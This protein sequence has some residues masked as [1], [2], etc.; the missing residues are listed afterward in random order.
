VT[1]PSPGVVSSSHY[2][3]ATGGTTQFGFTSVGSNSS[4]TASGW[5]NNCYIVA[6]KTYTAVSGDALTQF[7]VYGSGTGAC[8]VALYVI[9]GGV[10]TTRVGA[11][12]TITFSSSPAGWYTATVSIPLTAGVIYGMAIKWDSSA[13]WTMYW[14]SG[15]GGTQASIGSSFAPLP[16]TWSHSANSTDVWSFYANVTAAGGGTYLTDTFPYS[17]GDLAANSTGNWVNTNNSYAVTSGTVNMASGGTYSIVRRTTDLTADHY[18]EITIDWL[19]AMSGY[20]EIDCVCRLSSSGVTCYQAAANSDGTIHLF[21]IDS[22]STFPDI[23][24]AYNIPGGFADGVLRVTAIGNAIKVY[25]NSGLVLS[26]T[27][28]TYTGHFAG[29]AGFQNNTT[30]G[31]VTDWAGGTIP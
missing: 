13:G 10:P 24:T 6:G 31:N 16:S 18:S 8:D 22:L 21:R 20:S 4:T 25:W 28:A 29:M 26:A 11:V 14:Q 17:N 9:S 3:A 15:P 2:V 27:D 1:L 30:V 19:T 5:S 12:S 23:V 7:A